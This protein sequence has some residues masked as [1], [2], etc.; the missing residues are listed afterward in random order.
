MDSLL[1]FVHVCITFLPYRNFLSGFLAIWKVGRAKG[2][3]LFKLEYLS[4]AFAIIVSFFLLAFKQTR[5]KWVFIDYLTY[6]MCGENALSFFLSG[7]L[8]VCA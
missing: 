3:T 4:P 5:S 7:Y 2:Q 8:P 6:N 1:V